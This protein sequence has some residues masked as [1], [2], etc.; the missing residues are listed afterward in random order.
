MIEEAVKKQFENYALTKKTKNI[1]GQVY[2]PKRSSATESE[3]DELWKSYLADYY[4]G[5]KLEP[6]KL[7][8]LFRPEIAPDNYLAAKS[9]IDPESVCID[10]KSESCEYPW[11]P[12]SLSG[13][14][15][16]G[17]FGPGLGSDQ[18]CEEYG[19]QMID[20]DQLN[21][22]KAIFEDMC[23]LNGGVDIKGVVQ[24]SEGND[25]VGVFKN[26]GKSFY[27]EFDIELKRA[28]SWLLIFKVVYNGKTMFYFNVSPWL[29]IRL[30][31]DPTYVPLKGYIK[32]NLNIKHKFVIKQVKKGTQYFFGWKVFKYHNNQLIK[33][34][35]IEA[36]NDKAI[37]VQDVKIGV[38]ATSTFDLFTA[39]DGTLSNL[40]VVSDPE[41]I[42]QDQSIEDF[43][44]GGI[45]INGELYTQSG[46]RLSDV[47]GV[48]MEIGLINRPLPPKKLCF[49]MTK[50]TQQTGAQPEY[51]K[52][53][54][55]SIMDCEEA[56]STFLCW[57]EQNQCSHEFVNK[58][59]KRNAN[60]FIENE[61]VVNENQ[62]ILPEEEPTLDRVFV[63]SK[64]A[65]YEAKKQM[66]RATNKYNFRNMD[67]K[68]SYPYLFEILW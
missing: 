8:Q 64:R 48:D 57:K 1:T 46:Q 38:L 34:K 50:K 28:T 32:V 19:G 37:E 25:T 26:F 29:T 14:D 27:I 55:N 58:R 61:E 60:S 3:V 44:Y 42:F 23:Y 24:I 22:P 15:C 56:N 17:N 53:D 63:P 67:L 21:N 10:T 68:K 39:D 4:P 36:L 13:I 2:R 7:V 49:K 51:F 9:I 47:E 6:Q 54:T 43:W 52:I 5:T 62:M 11:R 12:S 45:L 20:F 30:Y 35:D 33:V 18:R 65:I 31:R 59:R 41:C 66:I 40:K 16:I